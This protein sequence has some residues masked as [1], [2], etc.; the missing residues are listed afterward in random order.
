MRPSAGRSL[1]RHW[2][3]R[4]HR[5]LG[6]ASIAFVLVLSVTGL[7]LNHAAELRLE[8]RYVQAPWLLSWYGIEAPAPTASFV[9]GDH[10]VVM[11]GDRLYFDV[12]ELGSA[13]LEPVGAVAAGGRIAVATPVEI[14]LL[15]PSGELIERV[16]LVGELPTDIERLGALGADLLIDSGGAQYRADPDLLRIEAWAGFAGTE[17]QW[18]IPSPVPVERL[19]ALARAYRGSGLSIE[20]VLLDL[21]SGRLWSRG[22]PLIVDIVAIAL[23]AL[24]GLGV[25]LWLRRRPRRR[26]A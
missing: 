7:A 21:H 17:P 9:V 14:L 6:L 12:R 2:L 25:L 22:G 26:Q 1:G 8:R 15:E 5:W 10:T 18:S 13:G 24:S 4:L 16:D 19:E 11:L 20:R 3:A 23:I